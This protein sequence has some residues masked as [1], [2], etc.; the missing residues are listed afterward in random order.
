MVVAVRRRLRWSLRQKLLVLFVVVSLLPLVSALAVVVTGGTEEVIDELLEL[1]ER[2]AVQSSRAVA[3][4]VERALAVLGSMAADEELLEAAAAAA[5]G[6]APSAK[7]RASERLSAVLR[8]LQ[9]D[10]TLEFDALRGYDQSGRLVAE[11][12]SAGAAP[13]ARETAWFVSA[14]RSP[15][16][17]EVL[18]TGGRRGVRFALPLR[19]PGGTGVLEG[20]L[21]TDGVLGHIADVLGSK[22]ASLVVGPGGEVVMGASPRDR[23]GP[24]GGSVEG[25]LGPLALSRLG[26]AY[27]R[28]SSSG[29]RWGSFLGRDLQ[30]RE[31]LVG[32]ARV[33]LPVVGAGTGAPEDESGWW[34]LS[35]LPRK[36][37]WA[38]FRR[39]LWVPA[40]AV[41]VTVAVLA[42]VAWV[43]SRSAL[44]PLEAM[45]AR[46]RYIAQG[47]FEERLQP[48]GSAEFQ[49]VAGAINAM[50]ERLAEVDSLRTEELVER[51]ALLERANRD[52]QEMNRYKNEF[53]ANMSHELRTPLNTVIGFT[54][55]VL[56]RSAE[57]LPERQRRHLQRVLRAGRQLRDLLGEVLDLSAI[58]AGRVEVTSETFRLATL[59][60]RLAAEF[61]PRVAE[62]GLELALHLTEPAL[63]VTTDRQKLRQVLSNLLSNAVKF[64]SA[65]RVDVSARALG[66][67]VQ[68]SVADTGPGIPP[69]AKEVIFEPFRQL[70]GSTTRL[71][72]GTGLGLAICQKLTRLLGGRITVESKVGEGSTF[73]VLLPQVLRPSEGDQDTEELGRLL[74]QVPTRPHPHTPLVLCVTGEVEH[75]EDLRR[76]VQEGGFQFV[77][78]RSGG[79]A[80]SRARRLRPAGIVVD[81][82]LPDVDG[83]EFLERLRAEAS[84]ARIP[85]A[86]RGYPGDA[87]RES[88]LGVGAVLSE[89]LS[90][91][92][93]RQVLDR[94]T[95]VAQHWVWM[96]EDD[97]AARA[98]VREF[99][100]GSGFAFR[101]FAS[102][103]EVRREL[104]RSRP[105][106][107]LVDLLLPGESGWAL[108]REL[109]G[110]GTPRQ[111]ELAVITARELTSEQERWL[112]ERG[113]PVILKSGLTREGFL[114]SLMGLVDWHQVPR[115]TSTL[116]SN[117]PTDAGGPSHG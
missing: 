105:Q 59:L 76:L 63:T 93:L 107:L 106:V 48:A 85:V 28:A 109:T 74:T 69:E 29:G 110:P 50:A 40:A 101:G 38:P 11:T 5:A 83:W 13:A 16:V 52:L 102:V 20:V 56:E 65:G 27:Q 90:G 113:V 15:V 21:V 84:T 1:Q 80:L 35:F 9:S 3:L 32:Y 19:L 95:G 104:E 73:S 43:V 4:T 46:A 14:R 94:L 60:R 70:D 91:E 47:H 36:R 98:L 79:E 12:S 45:T 97:P 87:E 100:G 25:G 34:L 66:S 49:Q 78:A 88:R 64:T 53:L 41:G 82:V 71:H 58:E 18:R 17:G 2:R 57:A 62:K 44:R 26:A 31:A 68:V 10:V 112:A 114:A 92:G 108:L 51:Q 67:M 111:F 24:T 72:E 75:L 81:M 117:P 99:C 37:V 115:T 39:R 86:V 103:A 7:A 8:T 23:P 89:P 42:A 61:R 54:E 55:L 22:H 33:E 96:V 116:G 30:G 77:G 6:S